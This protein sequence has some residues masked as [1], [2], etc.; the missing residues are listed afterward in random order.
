MVLQKL[1]T[2]SSEKQ[3]YR[4]YCFRRENSML[5][6]STKSLTSTSITLPNSLMKPDYIHHIMNKRIGILREDKIN[7]RGKYLH[8]I[9]EKFLKR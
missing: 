7:I 9:D 1:K 5:L 2:T 4:E 3:A 6:N 8:S